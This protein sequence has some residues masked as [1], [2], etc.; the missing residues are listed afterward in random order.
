MFIYCKNE[1][2]TILNTGYYSIQFTTF[3]KCQDENGGAIF[4]EVEGNR[5]IEFCFFINCQATKEKE[6]RGAAFLLRKGNNDIKYCC[7]ENCSAVIGGDFMEWGGESV[8]F[9][10][11]STTKCHASAHP[12]Y[13]SSNLIDVKYVNSSYNEL[14]QS[15]LHG[16]TLNIGGAKTISNAKFI[17]G[18]NN[19]KLQS[20]I[21]LDTLQNTDCYM[22]F[23]NAISNQNKNCLIILRNS[24]NVNLYISNSIFSSNK[25]NELFSTLSTSTNVMIT[26]N[27]CLFDFQESTPSDFIKL[28]SCTFNFILNTIIDTEFYCVMKYKESKI[29]CKNKEKYHFQLFIIVIVIKL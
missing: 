7:A 10:H 14:Q 13:L 21:T 4:C 12:A 27:N 11:I 23:I 5:Q 6:G 17:N 2:E 3:F 24:S 25:V 9:H 15:G 8:I 19:T 18:F 16:N 29:I 26:Y 28:E 1:H 22:N 20:I